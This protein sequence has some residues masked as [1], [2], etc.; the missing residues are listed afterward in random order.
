MTRSRVELI[1]FHVGVAILFLSF[2]VLTF[3]PILWAVIFNIGLY[4]MMGHTRT[5]YVKWLH[6]RFYWRRQ[7]KLWRNSECDYEDT[8]TMGRLKTKLK[9]LF[10]RHNWDYPYEPTSK[11]KERVRS[12]LKCPKRQRVIYDTDILG[13]GFWKWVDK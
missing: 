10:H 11:D 9:L 4:T 13:E 8:P 1:D 7:R 2:A 3:S 6:P 5:A 12:C